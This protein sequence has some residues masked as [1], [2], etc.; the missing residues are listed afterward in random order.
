M[1][2]R[3]PGSGAE[4]C[5]NLPLQDPL[6]RSPVQS[7]GRVAT[8]GAPADCARSGGWRPVCAAPRGWP[9]PAGLRSIDISSSTPRVSRSP[10]NPSGCRPAS[11]SRPSAF[12]TRPRQ[13]STA[14]RGSGTRRPCP[15]TGPAAS[16]DVVP[17]RRAPHLDPDHAGRA[18]S[19]RG[20][21][22]RPS[23]VQAGQS[24][25]PARGQQGRAHQQLD[26]PEQLLQ[27]SDDPARCHPRSAQPGRTREHANPVV[28]CR[29][30][31]RGESPTRALDGAAM[32]G[33]DPLGAA[34][35]GFA[36]QAGPMCTVPAADHMAGVESAERHQFDGSRG[37]RMRQAPFAALHVACLLPAGAAFR[38]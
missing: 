10:R 2:A 6:A 22:T 12:P 19:Q 31:A 15:P 11:R 17:V 21:R 25:V 13:P 14:S 36:V 3:G 4:E 7:T 5:P 16:A 1:I 20:A 33:Y 30:A 34:I 37:Q 18:Q 26:A 9:S 24:P 23:F 32:R 29:D 38:I 35:G 27:L 8:D 28:Q